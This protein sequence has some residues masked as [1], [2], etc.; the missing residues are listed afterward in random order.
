LRP[1]WVLQWLAD[2]QKIMP[3]TRM[4]AFFPATAQF[5]EGQSPFPNVLGGDA[6]AQI[7]AI[8]DHLFITVGGGRRRS[9]TL[10]TTNK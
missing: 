1:E 4:P 9:G 5:P 3:G 10:S 2:P 7:Q 6:K 8:R